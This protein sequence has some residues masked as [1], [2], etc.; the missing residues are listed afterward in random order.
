MKGYQYGEIYDLHFNDNIVVIVLAWK[1]FQGGRK[2][3]T[4]FI[5]YRIEGMSLHWEN[6]PAAKIPFEDGPIEEYAS[7]F[8]GGVVSSI[9]STPDGHNISIDMESGAFPIHNIMF[10]LTP[11]GTA[12]GSIEINWPLSLL[13]NDEPRPWQE[14]NREGPGM[15]KRFAVSDHLLFL[16]IIWQDSEPESLVIDCWAIYWRRDLSSCKRQ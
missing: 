5:E 16:D 3:Q 1:R 6:T 15:I 14:L 8:N 7:Y 12:K 10:P 9:N 4:D 11:Q 13:I 2:Q